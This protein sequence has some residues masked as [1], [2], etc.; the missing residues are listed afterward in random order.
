MVPSADLN[1]TVG[2]IFYFGYLVA[3]FPLVGMMGRFPVAKFLAV[4]AM[5]W[6]LMTFLMAACH[7]SQGLMALRFFMGMMEA[8]ALPGLTLI[9]TMWQVLALDDPGC[10]AP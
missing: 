3:E 6:A 5:G 1:A 8:P 7:N 9:T 10:T 2:S 4:M